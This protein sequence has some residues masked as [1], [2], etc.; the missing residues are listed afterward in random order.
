MMGFAMDPP[1]SRMNK[2]DSEDTV[3][4]VQQRLSLVSANRNVPLHAALGR[5]RLQVRWRW[6]V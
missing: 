1:A 3:G 4:F 5:T 6:R 2:G